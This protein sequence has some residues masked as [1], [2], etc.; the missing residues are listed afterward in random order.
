MFCIY[1]ITNLINGKSYIGKSEKGDLARWQTHLR[2][3]R[4]GKN[5][6]LYA[7]M[8]KHGIENFSI[9]VVEE[10]DAIEKL[11]ERERLWIFLMNSKDPAYGYNMTDGGGGGNTMGGR[12]HKPESIEKIREWHTGKPLPQSAKDKLSQYSKERVGEKSNRFNKSVPT[13]EVVRLYQ[14]GQSTRQIAAAFGMEKTAIIGRLKRADVPLR[15]NCRD[16]KKAA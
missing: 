8:K 4:R 6:R 5:T 2:D 3:F 10:V 16:L 11:D 12:N 15:P 1:Q 7:S 14:E 13:E 9:T